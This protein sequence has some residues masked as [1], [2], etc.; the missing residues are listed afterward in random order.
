[1]LRGP[2]RRGRGG[3][4]RGVVRRGRGRRTRR[5]AR[6]GRGAA[7]SRGTVGG[8]AVGMRR[9]RV[10]LVRRVVL[11]LALVGG[12]GGAL[13]ALAGG[14][15]GPA[16]DGPSPEIPLVAGAPARPLVPAVPMQAVAGAPTEAKRLTVRPAKSI[17]SNVEEPR[18]WEDPVSHEKVALPYYPL[19]S[20]RGNDV[21]PAAGAAPDVP[22]ARWSQMHAT[23]YKDVR[24][25]TR[26]EAV[27]LAHDP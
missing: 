7:A 25:L 27:R 19:Y 26:A 21:G 3:P 18:E 8:S 6:G 16:H 17:S 22:A 23:V 14:V 10:P 1:I 24:E 13:V 4:A 20:L 5:G 11:F 15:A 2:R 12:L 9:G